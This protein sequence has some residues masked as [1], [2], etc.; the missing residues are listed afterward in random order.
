MNESELYGRTIRVNLAKPM[1]NKEGGSKAI[2]NTDEYLQEHASGEN[3]ENAD[4][5]QQA[6][7][8][9]TTDEVIVLELFNYW[10]YYLCV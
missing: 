4:D 1:K 7:S 8:D 6:T 3:K 10:L 5:D 2:W 9:Q